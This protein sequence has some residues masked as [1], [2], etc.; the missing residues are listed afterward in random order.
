MRI[1]KRVA[2]PDLIQLDANKFKSEN[3]AEYH[4]KVQ[5]DQELVKTESSEGE[6]PVGTSPSYSQ[7]IVKIRKKYHQKPKC[8]VPEC[9][10]PD[11]QRLINLPGDPH[12][13]KQWIELFALNEDRM[14]VVNTKVC[15]I[16]FKEGDFR[17]KMLKRGTLPSKHLPPVSTTFT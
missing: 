13:R 4:I 3:K 7:T 14:R 11:V 5:N 6:N 16:H 9:P 1:K 2:N 12:V 17:N 15:T 10:N 8:C